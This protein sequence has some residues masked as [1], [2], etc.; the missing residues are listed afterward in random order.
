MI[1]RIQNKSMITAVLTTAV[2][3]L[4]LTLTGC[5]GSRQFDDLR[6]DLDEIKRSNQ[7]TQQKVEHLDSLISESNEADI[8]LRNDIRVTVDEMNRQMSNLLESY[9]QLMQMLHEISSKQGSRLYSSPGSQNIPS[10]GGDTEP[11]T[12]QDTTPPPPINCDTAFDDSF[13]LMR[14]GEWDKAVEGYQ[15]FLRYC[16]NHEKVESALYWSGESYY[17]L[18][19]YSE[20]IEQFQ[21]LTEQFKGS[22]LLSAALYKMARSHQELGQMDKARTIYQRLTKEFEGTLEA[23]QAKERLK[24]L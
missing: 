17:S 24:D 13:I 21:K 6:A 3:C 4:V 15:E 18:E 23:Q 20:A 22:S 19:K 10:G 12:M 11:T 2:I 7:T 14:Q 9:D 16:P 5:V 8:K 1:M